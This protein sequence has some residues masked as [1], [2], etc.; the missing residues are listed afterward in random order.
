MITL[1]TSA[2]LPSNIQ[3]PMKQILELDMLLSLDG[4]SIISKHLFLVYIGFKEVHIPWYQ[5][6]YS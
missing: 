6:V 2:Q 5:Q 3:I 4:F 1:L